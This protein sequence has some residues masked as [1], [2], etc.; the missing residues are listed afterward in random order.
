MS[1]SGPESR[2]EPILTPAR[3]ISFGELSSSGP[4]SCSHPFVMGILG[5]ACVALGASLLVAIQTGA[6][7]G[8]GIA[9]VLAGLGLASGLFLASIG[10]CAV[11]A[12]TPAP[13]LAWFRAEM[14]SE[15]LALCLLSTIL[16]NIAGALIVVWLVFVAGQYALADAQVGQTALT[17]ARQKCALPFI[18]MLI[19]GLFGGVLVAVALWLA[20]GAQTLIDRAI[21]VAIPAIILVACGFT[22]CVSDLYL[23]PMGLAIQSWKAVPSEGTAITLGAF[24]FR[25]FIPGAT[26][27]LLG[28]GFAVGALHWAKYTR[29][30]VPSGDTSRPRRRAPRSDATR[31]LSLRG[32]RRG[33]PRLNDETPGDP[34]T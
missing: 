22:H 34:E 1:E 20:A 23:V 25:V 33:R 28:A 11:F 27:G 8:Y 6:P 5:G 16:G 2:S 32:T 14:T 21:A 3:N 7:G 30:A 4:L 12:G 19:R 13:F 26:G 15:R 24:I 18:S 29:A 10:R 9:A 31:A 17:I